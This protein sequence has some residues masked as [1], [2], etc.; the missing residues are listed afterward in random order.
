MNTFEFADE[1][2][3]NRALKAKENAERMIKEA[4]DKESMAKAQ[5][6]LMRAMARI[7]AAK[8]K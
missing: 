7:S 1:I 5:S 3:L 8:Y 4:S 6:K 2:D